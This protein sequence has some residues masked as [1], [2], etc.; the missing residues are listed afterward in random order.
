MQAF[1]RVVESVAATLIAS[2]I[3]WFATNTDEGT[4]SYE[5]AISALAQ[6]GAAWI[7]PL[8][9]M[10]VVAAAMSVLALGASAVVRAPQG[11]AD[12]DSFEPKQL[13]SKAGWLLAGIA[14]LLGLT[15]WSFA[16]LNN[17]TVWG[18]ALLVGVTF[19]VLRWLWTS[20]RRLNRLLN[21]PI[22]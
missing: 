1:G 17:G 7:P 4:R 16:L 9:I 20:S 8:W 2:A 15:S 3:L 13:L 11:H 19:A 6:V 18:A 10:A 21:P 14:V 22:R 12:F 5:A